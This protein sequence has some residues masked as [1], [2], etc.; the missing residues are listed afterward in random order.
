MPGLLDGKKATTFPADVEQFRKTFPKILTQ[1]GY[2][3]VHEGKYLTSQ[4][5]ARSYDVAL[6]LVNKLYGE[7]V[8]AGVGRGL[9][10][11]WPMPDLKYLAA[12]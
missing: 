2:S 3:F 1:E 12:H 8:A 9:V 11:S 10:L 6:Y 7:K 4:G 5:G